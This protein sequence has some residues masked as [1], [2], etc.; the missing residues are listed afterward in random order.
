MAG[1]QEGKVE[2]SKTAVIST[3]ESISVKVV[4]IKATFINYIQHTIH[5][6]LK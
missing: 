5:K 6:Y 2:K 1:R 4:N 3:T